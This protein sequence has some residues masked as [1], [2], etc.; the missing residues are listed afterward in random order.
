MEQ[1]RVE[2]ERLNQ[3]MRDDQAQIDRLKAESKRIKADSDV[4]RGRTT[5]RLNELEAMLKTQQDTEKMPIPEL[6]PNETLPPGIHAATLAEIVEQ[7]GAGSEARER[8]GRLLQLIV[9]VA[10]N[11]PTI[12]R[13]LVW[14]SFITSKAEPN[15]LDY[16]IVVS[17]EHNRTRIDLPPRRFLVPF[18]ARQFYD[19]DKS[20]LVIQ[21]YPLPRYIELVDFVCASRIGIFGILE[22][23]LRGETAE[24]K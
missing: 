11:Y 23:S 17:V 7:H 16:S 22:I 9:E 5:A 19:V 18:E 13:I 1:M 4:I 24:Q 15:D 8:Q 2:M 21:D 10:R 3:K 14:G 12:K 6:T 20:Y